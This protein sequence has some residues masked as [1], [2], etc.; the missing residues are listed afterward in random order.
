MLDLLNA[1]VN[2]ALNWVRLR[3]V[4]QGEYPYSLQKGTQLRENI[5]PPASSRR[6]PFIDLALLASNNSF[7][8]RIVRVV[9]HFS[10]D[11]IFGSA[12]P[13]RRAFVQERTATVAVG[14]DERAALGGLD[15]EG[16]HG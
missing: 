4:L 5:N 13:D 2:A 10:P 11:H 1:K 6:D 8:H 3:L 9:Q 14:E 16:V 15:G 12:M 7:R